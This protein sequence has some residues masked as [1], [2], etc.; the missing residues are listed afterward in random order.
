MN[1]HAFLLL[2]SFVFCCRSADHAP[3]DG[4]GEGSPFTHTLA[5]W[6]DFPWLDWISRVGDRERQGHLGA[7]EEEAERQEEKGLVL[8]PEVQG[9][10]FQEGGAWNPS[11]L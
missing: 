1:C 10:Q 4:C 9:E 7:R 5:L 3:E 2:A 11:A 6:T 8:G